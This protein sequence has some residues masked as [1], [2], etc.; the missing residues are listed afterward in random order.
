MYSLAGM[1]LIDYHL[2]SNVSHDGVGRI[3]EHL[4]QAAEAGISEICFTEHLDFYPSIDAQSCGT[5]P[6]EAQL[7][8]YLE[9]VREAAQSTT[10]ALRAGVELDY[11]PEADRWVRELL[12]KFSFDFVLGSAHNVD[13]LGISDREGAEL[14]FQRRGAWQG[15]LDYY[16]IVEKAVSTG[17]F[18]SF[19]HLDLMKRFRPENAELMKQGELRERIVAILDRVAATGTGIEINGAGL[20][21]DPREAYPS[22]ELL[23]LARERGVTILTIGSD[24]HRPETVG[25]HLAECL[26]LAQEAGYHHIYTFQE[27]APR[28]VQI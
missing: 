5:I 17:L 8:R 13:A 14:Y 22:L 27:R 15:C 23:K 6:T 20:I 11:K 4:L 2:H 18:D 16:D 26:Q 21:H 7:E 9:D 10:V 12:H 19:A 28:A 3:E 25:R 1:K 24:S